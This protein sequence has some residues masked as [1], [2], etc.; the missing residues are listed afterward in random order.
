[1]KKNHLLLMLLC[2]LVPLAGIA[3]IALFRV[4]ASSVLY[5]GLVL[6]CPLMHVV[7]MAT[8]RHKHAP[9]AGAP[10]CH[11]AANPGRV[12]GSSAEPAV[13]RQPG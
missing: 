5:F 10:S 4:P 6:L 3:A 7:M 9:E 2:C 12:E 11:P 13:A 1:M 8:M